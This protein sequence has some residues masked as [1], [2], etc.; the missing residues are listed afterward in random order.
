MTLLFHGHRTDDWH[1]RRETTLA[2]LRAQTAGFH[3]LHWASP[4]MHDQACGLCRVWG[5]DTLII[6]DQYAGS[7]CDLSLDTLAELAG[8]PEMLCTVP[9]RRESGEWSHYQR[10]ENGAVPGLAGEDWADLAYVSVLRVHGHVQDRIRPEPSWH[11]DVIA[12]ALADQAHRAGVR[13]HLHWSGA[14][15]P[16]EGG[17][18][19]S[20]PSTR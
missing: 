4:A 10:G 6:V 9:F 5:M 18:C 19:R 14:Y 13:Y 16:A 20:T 17:S 11:D 2:L 1:G 8:C 12:M 15:V 7:L 3:V